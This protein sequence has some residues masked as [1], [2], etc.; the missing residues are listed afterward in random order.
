MTPVKAIRAKCID[1][2]CGQMYEVSKC[3]CVECPLYPFRMGHNP[4]RKGKGGN[5]SNLFST[6]SSGER[7]AKVGS[8][9]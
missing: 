2:C 7:T 9:T 5:L 6:D 3:V 1:C 8:E 4:N